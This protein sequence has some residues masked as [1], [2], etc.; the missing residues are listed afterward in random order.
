MNFFSKLVLIIAMFQLSLGPLVNQFDHE[1]MTPISWTLFNQASAAPQV[2]KANDTEGAQN[3]TENY[4][5]TAI[6]LAI[7]LITKVLV[8]SLRQASPDTYLF[9][10]GGVLYFISELKTFSDISD[11]KTFEYDPDDLSQRDIT[12]AAIEEQERTSSEI[13]KIATWKLGFQLAAEAAFLAATGLSIMQY[14]EVKKRCTAQGRPFVT[15]ALSEPEQLR[16]SCDGLI[17]RED[18]QHENA[19][20]AFDPLQNNFACKKPENWE[21]AKCKAICYEKIALVKADL[22]QSTAAFRQVCSQEEMM[23]VPST[24]VQEQLEREIL[25]KS[26]DQ[27]CRLGDDYCPFMIP[28]PPPV[29]PTDPST[30]FDQ[31]KLENTFY[32]Y[33]YNKFIIEFDNLVLSDANAAAGCPGVPDAMLEKFAM[34]VGGALSGGVSQMYG[35]AASGVD[36]VMGSNGAVSVEATIIGKTVWKEMHDELGEAAAKKVMASACSRA[37]KVIAKQAAKAAAKKTATKVGILI[38][39]AAASGALAL[40]VWAI[41][42]AAISV[43]FT[44]RDIYGLLKFLHTTSVGRRQMSSTMRNTYYYL[45]P[46]FGMILDIQNACR[47]RGLLEHGDEGYLYLRPMNCSLV[48]KLDYD[49]KEVFSISEIQEEVLSFY[50]H[51]N[52]FQHRNNNSW[53]AEIVNPILPAYAEDGGFSGNTL[54]KSGAKLAA[55]AILMMALSKMFGEVIEKWIY[56]PKGRMIMFG[57]ISGLTATSIAS[58]SAILVKSKENLKNVQSIKDE[59][60]NAK[61]EGEGTPILDTNEESVEQEDS[62]SLIDQSIFLESFTSEDKLVI[63]SIFSFNIIND[64]FASSL[65][66]G[67]DYKIPCITKELRGSKRCYPTDRAMRNM[68]GPMRYSNYSLIKKD[69]DL[70]AKIGKGISNKKG[71]SDQ[72]GYMIADLGTR[73]DHLK[74]VN[75][76]LEKVVNRKKRQLGEKQLDFEKLHKSFIGGLVSKAKNYLKKNNI[77]LEEIF[78]NRKTPVITNKAP[79]GK[80]TE[81]DI[82]NIVPSVETQNDVISGIDQERKD[83]QDIE[84]KAEETYDFKGLDIETRTELSIFKIIS[85]RYILNPELFE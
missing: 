58:M 14:I 85:R 21:L 4:L 13:V 42:F 78:S 71:I 62:T 57:A 64:A 32:T 31:S 24:E 54:L 72:V 84:V 18:P 2:F 16:A 20:R 76:K 45:D 40:S 3:V 29:I 36:S 74:Q 46:V 69:I 48:S 66:F 47:Y 59:L 56:N 34:S 55:G 23:T 15:A 67:V 51:Q 49:T 53:I 37:Q 83:I 50:S 35:K 8:K 68:L 44:L 19:P 81:E 17:V 75:K 7:G 60:L 25:N 6:L 33:F 5:S 12:I 52:N 79:R 26:A 73:T 27:T 22:M 28:D 61:K 82:K 41:P 1:Y 10:I 9:I 11:N 63:N 65:S 43:Y 38:A 80:Q 77:S 70:V 39:R 30:F